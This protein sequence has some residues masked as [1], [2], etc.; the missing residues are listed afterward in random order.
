[1]QNKLLTLFL[2][3]F[4]SL[5]F[6]QLKAQ[7]IKTRLATAVKTFNNDS[8]MNNGLMSLYVIDRKT[9]AVVYDYNGRL[10]LSPASTQKVITSVTAYEVLGKDF[11]YET[12]FSAKK[13]SATFIEI[14]GNGDP[15]FGSWR[16]T[17]TKPENI[18]YNAVKNLSA[19]NEL[20]ENTKIVVQNSLKDNNPL[21]GGYMWQDAGNYYGSGHFDV[22]W[23]EN[24]YDIYYDTKS[25]SDIRIK[26]TEPGLPSN[27]TIKN[28]LKKGGSG[29]N[30]IMYATPY[31]NQILIYG[32]I[33]SGETNFKVSG[34]IP[35][36]APVLE[37][38]LQNY[39]GTINKTFAKDTSA[40]YKENYTHY[41]PTLDQICY[42]FLRK[43]VNLYGEALI[44]TTGEKL[45]NGKGTDNGTS[46]VRNFWKEKGLSEYELKLEDGSGLSP[47]NKITTHALVTALDFAK[48]KTWF[49]GFY[50]GLPVYNDM[51]MKSGTIAGCKGFAGYTDKYIFAILVNNY[52]GA[53][54]SIVN[55]M[56]KVLDVL[57]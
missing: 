37:N 6:T 1:M 25:Y 8:Q 9:G 41:S 53:H 17:A 12:N 13:D 39:F 42:W 5:T 38:E 46:A 14:T 35:D 55:K 24:Q 15:T 2:I 4:C 7:T 3:C 23:N 11:R 21:P 27:I 40:L 34:S 47:Q 32:T 36:P 31:S 51:K 10:G 54:S 18:F 20:N 16:Y 57:K 30:S 56:Y 49:N 45:N 48:N 50:E 26:K 29:D 43:S 19:R 52:N 28:Y 44:K 33:P 22:N